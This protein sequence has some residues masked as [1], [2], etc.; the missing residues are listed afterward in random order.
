ML[1]TSSTSSACG[2]FRGFNFNR[3]GPC[4]PSHSCPVRELACWHLRVGSPNPAF[5]FCLTSTTNFIVVGFVIWGMASGPHFKAPRTCRTARSLL[6]LSSL[7]RI[8]GWSLCPRNPR[9]PTVAKRVRI[10]SSTS[11]FSGQAHILRLIIHGILIWPGSHC[12][13]L[14]VVQLGSRRDL[15]CTCSCTHGAFMWCD[16]ILDEG[17]HFIQLG[18]EGGRSLSVGFNLANIFALR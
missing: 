15:G 12:R 7:T 13:N 17:A 1:A 9:V 11:H 8:L 18:R 3:T 5:E 2:V 10:C 4:E 14:S 6:L 16:Q